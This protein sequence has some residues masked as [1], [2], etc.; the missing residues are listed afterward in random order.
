MTWH[1]L[2]VQLIKGF[3]AVEQD[4][5]SLAIVFHGAPVFVSRILWGDRDMEFVEFLL[6]VCMA[7]EIDPSHALDRNSEIV[8]GSFVTRADAIFWRHVAMIETLQPA[9]VQ[10]PLALA[11]G[12]AHR[13]AESGATAPI[14]ETG[15]GMY[16][17]V[18]TAS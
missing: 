3:E 15:P 11:S 14:E 18:P 5:D 2:K 12:L 7:D 10:F 4:K 1:E 17:R 9:E 8:L 16:W 13:M 6:L